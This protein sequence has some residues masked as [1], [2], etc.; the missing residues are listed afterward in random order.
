MGL[1]T[2]EAGK[3]QDEKRIDAKLDP[4]ARYNLLGFFS[5]LLEIDRRNNPE[6]Y[7]KQPEDH[8]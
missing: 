7:K 4:E 5:L 6:K 8:D 1:M 3:I 2:D